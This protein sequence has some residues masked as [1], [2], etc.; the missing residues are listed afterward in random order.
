MGMFDPQEIELF[1]A[2]EI[3]EEEE[4]KGWGPFEALRFET[5]LAAW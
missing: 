4:A 2:L 3:I 5:G 1:V